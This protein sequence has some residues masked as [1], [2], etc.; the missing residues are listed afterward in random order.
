MGVGAAKT[1]FEV[2]QIRVNFIDVVDNDRWVG[3][4]LVYVDK[5][6]CF[7]LSASC[8]M[9]HVHFHP[10]VALVTLGWFDCLSASCSS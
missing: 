8:S 6:G 4:A 5:V 3:L 7:C 9:L 10:R 2:A 1:H